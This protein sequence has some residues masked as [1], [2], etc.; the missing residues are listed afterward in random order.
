VILNVN[1][2]AAAVGTVAVTGT[3]IVVGTFGEL[4]VP[5]VNHTVGGA[6]ALGA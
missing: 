5:L 6:H 4:L 2:T 1:I 3:A